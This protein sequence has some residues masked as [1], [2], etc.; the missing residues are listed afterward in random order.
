MEGEFDKILRELK[1]RDASAKIYLEQ[2]ASDA[3]LEFVRL[4][5]NSK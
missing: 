5:W 3:I 4:L 1:E 2:P